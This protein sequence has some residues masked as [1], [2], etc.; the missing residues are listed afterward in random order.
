MGIWLV[1]KRQ[2]KRTDYFL[3]AAEQ[4]HIPVSFADWNEVDQVDLAGEV[5]KLD[6]PSYQT[7]RKSVV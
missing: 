2:T 6:P 7:D 1:G 5:V 4:L 3:K